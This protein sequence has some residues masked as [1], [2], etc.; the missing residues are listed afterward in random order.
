[1]VQPEGQ[2]EVQQNGL[3][4]PFSRIFTDRAE[5]DWA[6]DLLRET[7]RRLQVNDPYDQRLAVTLTER[8]GKLF[9]RLNFGGWTVLGFRGP[10]QVPERVDMALL[11]S[12]VAWDERLAP[13]VFEQ[14]GGEPEVRS[15]ELPLAVVRPLT[16]QLQQAYE[17]TLDFIADKFRSWKKAIHWKRHNPELVEAFFNPD[18][19]AQLFASGLSEPEFQYERHFT[20]FH[21]ELAEEEGIYEV[22]PVLNEENIVTSD[23]FAFSIA[24]NSEEQLQVKSAV[25]LVQDQDKEKELVEA[26]NRFRESLQ[27]SFIVRLRRKRAEQ[28]RELLSNPDNIDLETF[29]REVWT[30]QSQQKVSKTVNLYNIKLQNWDQITEIEQAIESGERELH[31][32]CMWGSGSKVYAPRL[33]DED[34]KIQHIRQALQ[35]LN[36]PEL[37]PLQKA[38]R[39]KGIYGFG[40]NISTG[41]VMVF[42]P[43]E[44]GL[45]NQAGKRILKN[46]GYEAENSLNDY[47][48]KLQYL[49]EKLK[50]ADFIELDWF[51]YVFNQGRY[52]EVTNSLQDSEDQL[53]NDFDT[54]TKINHQQVADYIYSLNQLVE[55]TGM[56]E[57]SLKRY[58][59]A[60]ERKKQVIL[61]G[62]PGTG[63][64]FLAERLAR[65]LVAGGDGIV[66][67]VQFHPAYA[68]EDFMQ[69][70]RPEA[71][72]RGELTY[73]L[74]PGRFL[75]FCQKAGR[76]QGACVLIIDE[77]NRA[78]LARVFGELMYLLEYRERAIPLA[79]G[80]LF[81]IPANVRLIGT[82]NTADRS[83]ALVDHALRR[84]FA[85]LALQPD[86]ALLRRYHQ[87]Q[88]SG[89]PVE[90]LIKVLARLNRQ[91][92]DPHYAVGV[93][94]FLRPDL[95]A[96]IEDIWAMEIEPYL[97]E[98]FFDQP[99]SV[100]S[101]RWPEVK[102]EIMES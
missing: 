28:L 14:R 59:R 78:N 62:P 36:R 80:G 98:Y 3:A 56:D 68:Y 58:L 22:E 79:G 74:L 30:S 94:F 66:E 69:G 43:T 38:Q 51:L 42:H 18:K 13:F 70:L 55:E 84:R 87:R 63:K 33:K 90:G 93:T 99:A 15:Y 41:L 26:F 21:H 10:G 101:F 71:G 23:N 49:R 95:A 48:A 53:D 85:F 5:A 47:E 45:Y 6:F 61:Y 73:H 7:A 35:I 39:I 88:E 24:S 34:Q 82:M 25:E 40:D 44:F 50:A 96:E 29:N 31:G 1:M 65:Y 100:D 52:A 72:P 8:S 11:A 92:G 12:A 91:I 16:S 17:T 89:F 86:Y 2:T 64:T 81:Q 27:A 20:A 19:R 37:T 60:I 97:E 4:E 102:R 57:T 54:G 32:N 83:I 77:I 9:L 75:E 46:I 67:L 76:R